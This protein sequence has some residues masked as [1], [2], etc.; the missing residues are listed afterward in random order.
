[1]ILGWTVWYLLAV[2]IPAMLKS[3]REEREEFLKIQEEARRE[4]KD[5][6]TILAGSLNVL[7]ATLVASNRPSNKARARE[8]IPPDRQAE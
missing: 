2:G 5:S 6:L 8:I 4:F 3:A 7:T 1:M